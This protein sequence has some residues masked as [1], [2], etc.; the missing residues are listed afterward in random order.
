M[1]SQAGLWAW[2]GPR[3]QGSELG[4]EGGLGNRQQPLPLGLPPATRKWP[5]KRKRQDPGTKLGLV[6]DLALAPLACSGLAGAG[7][8]AA[9][10]T[11]FLLEHLCNH[12]AG[13]GRQLTFTSSPTSGPLIGWGR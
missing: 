10:Q 13:W 1:K 4:V 9:P 12:R 3:G 6:A 11:R 5:W 7:S 8:C 2:P